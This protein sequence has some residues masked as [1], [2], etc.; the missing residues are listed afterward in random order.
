MGSRADRD[1]ISYH[2]FIC[3][4]ILE[5]LHVAGISEHFS[6]PPMIHHRR[7]TTTLWR[8]FSVKIQ[9][10]HLNFQFSNS[11]IQFGDSNFQFDKSNVQF[12]NSNFSI[13]QFKYSIYSTI[14]IFNSAIQ[15]FT[16]LHKSIR[17]FK[18]SIYSTIQILN[19]GIQIFTS[20]HKSQVI[21]LTI[22]KN[23]KHSLKLTLGVIELTCW[24]ECSN[25][26]IE[27]LYSLIESVFVIELPNP[28][29]NFET[30]NV[31][32]NTANSIPYSLRILCGFFYV[33]QGLNFEELWDAV[34]GLSSLLAERLERQQHFILSYLK[35]SA[36]KKKSS[37]SHSK[38]W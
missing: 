15:I 16:S 2:I 27:G 18:Y 25:C 36:K 37:L 30:K 11:N 8:V 29:L 22:Q 12:V 1:H 21:V 23:P 28:R 13:R 38:K 3:P 34:Y 9:T 14:Q 24:I 19:S 5:W 10:C 6:L 35:K 4:R 31:P 7:Q 17:Q 26:W 20:L 33:P 32:Y